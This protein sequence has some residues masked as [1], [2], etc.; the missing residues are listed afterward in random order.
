VE[1]TEGDV[2]SV[3]LPRSVQSALSRGSSSQQHNLK[4]SNGAAQLHSIEQQINGGNEMILPF[5][6]QNQ[7]TRQSPEDR[8]LHLDL[9]QLLFAPQ[10]R[11][12]A[13]D[14]FPDAC[15]L[16]LPFFYDHIIA[17]HIFQQPIPY[18]Y[19]HMPHF[20]SKPIML[21]V[22]H[23]LGAFLQVS[24]RNRFRN[25]FTDI[26]MHLQYEAALTKNAMLSKDAPR[27]IDVDVSRFFWQDRTTMS[28]FN[29][30]ILPYHL[31]YQQAVFQDCSSESIKLF[32]AKLI[33]KLE[34][35]RPRFLSIDDDLPQDAN[36]ECLRLHRHYFLR[37]M[38]QYWP[39]TAPWELRARVVELMQH[40]LGRTP[41]PPLANDPALLRYVRDGVFTCACEHDKFYGNIARKSWAC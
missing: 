16:D 4:V 27:V 29:G 18:W 21:D 28:S 23:K 38:H 36:T 26:N 41:W 34:I 5:A 10:R 17:Q 40:E 2:L 33:C 7:P 24:R 12:L 25:Q 35:D 8:A 30:T 37:F 20:W 19:A 39:Q 9:N 13:T 22:E 14:S 6:V 1:N 32:W 15:F 31:N 3:V 11:L